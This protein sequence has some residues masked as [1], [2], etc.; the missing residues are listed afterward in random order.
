MEEVASSET[1]T[2]FFTHEEH[3]Q[4]GLCPKRFFE[5]GRATRT[6][7]YADPRARTSRDERYVKRDSVDF[8]DR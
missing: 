3:M 1:R 2:N 8:T 6:V 4:K 7:F 5:T